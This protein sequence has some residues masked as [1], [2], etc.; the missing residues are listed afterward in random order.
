MFVVPE[1]K[2]HPVMRGVKDMHA[3]AGAYSAVLIEGRRSSAK[4]RCSIP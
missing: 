1:H 4:T 3:L 2:K